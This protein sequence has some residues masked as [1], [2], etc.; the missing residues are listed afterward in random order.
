MKTMIAILMLISATTADIATNTANADK[1]C[2]W[3]GS[4]WICVDI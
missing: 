2:H 3:S 1:V 4:M